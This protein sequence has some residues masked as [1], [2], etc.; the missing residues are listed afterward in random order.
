M[1]FFG[2]FLVSNWPRESLR[3]DTRV[4]INAL[5]K[6]L[7]SRCNPCITQP[8]VSGQRKRENCL[9]GH[10]LGLHFKHIN[11]F[12]L[13]YLYFLKA[14]YIKYIALI[15]SIFL[16]F[17]TIIIEKDNN[18]FYPVNFGKGMS[19]FTFFFLFFTPLTCNLCNRVCAIVQELELNQKIEIHRSLLWALRN[20]NIII[21]AL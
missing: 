6:W 16:I 8:F 13:W 12:I 14:Q 2:V 20:I 7:I 3:Y 11:T 10:P 18:Y 17:Y 9:H 5:I 21:N 1:S 19:F 15:R 4:G